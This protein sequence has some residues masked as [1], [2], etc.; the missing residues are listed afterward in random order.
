MEDIARKGLDVLDPGGLL[1]LAGFRVQEL[2]AALNRLR[3]LRVRVEP[4]A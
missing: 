3:T 2:A 1:D 4:P